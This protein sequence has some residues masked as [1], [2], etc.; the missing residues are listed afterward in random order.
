MSNI[1][2]G[3]HL[4]T[5]RFNGSYT[6]HGIYIGDGKVIHYSGLA[7]RVEGGPIETTSLK[8]FTG[9]QGYN[10]R[11]YQNS[12]YQGDIIVSRAKSRLGENKY[13]LIT[14]NCEHFCTWCILGDHASQQVN[15]VLNLVTVQAT[16]KVLAKQVAK[17]VP[18]VALVAG[19]IEAANAIRS[20]LKGNITEEQLLNDISST[21][22]TH[23]SI[24][25]YGILGQ[26]V[27]PVPILGAFIGS[28]V[29]Y[30]LGHMLTQS[31]FLALG[32]SDIARYARQRRETIEAICR[33]VIP[34]MRQHREELETLLAV[35]F[36]ERKHLLTQAFDGMEAALI[37]WDADAF[38]QQLEAVNK[39]FGQ[40][41]PFK[42]FDEFDVFMKDKNSVFVL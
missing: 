26:A 4:I 3:S 19:T 29:G 34:A 35:H 37:S 27:I 17:S 14:N 23:T 1:P 8:E 36:A 18:S 2:L 30:F 41:L 7:S 22:I 5:S 9:G 13:H 24:F 6:H 40:S 39:A 25:Y 16:K 38:T 31:G 32:E 11:H 33:E 12:V 15:R 20:Y 28:T 10:I 21:A 42:S